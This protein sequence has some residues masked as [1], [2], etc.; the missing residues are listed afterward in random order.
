MTIEVLNRLNSMEYLHKYTSEEFIKFIK[1]FQDNDDVAL[2]CMIVWKKDHEPINLNE[3]V[4]SNPKEK[5]YLFKD[6]DGNIVVC[7]DNDIKRY[8]EVKE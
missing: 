3:K 7:K 4:F 2:Q 5:A 1:G 6:K 8:G